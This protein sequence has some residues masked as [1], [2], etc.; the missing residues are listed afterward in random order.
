LRHYNKK[1]AS[2]QANRRR[3]EETLRIMKHVDTP[4]TR[5]QA[6]LARGDITPPVGIYHRM[7]GAAVH[8]QATGVHRPL[9]A[10]LLYLRACPSPSASEGSRGNPRWRSGSDALIIALD[11]CVMDGAEMTGIRAAACRATA[12]EP[13]QVHVTLSHTHGSGWMSRAR[14]HFPGGELIGPYLDE[15]ATKI[16]QLAEQAQRTVLPA[17][18]VYGQGRC[19]LAAQRD[20]W[21]ADNKQYVCGFN[22]T[23]A[24]DDTVLVARI[25]GEDGKCLATIV[26]YACHPTTLA[27]DNTAISPDYV[28]AMREVVEHVTGAPCLFLQGASGDLGP[29]EGFVGDWAVADRNGRQL[30]HAA[31]SALEALPPPG[32]RFVY[33][34][35]VVSGTT[36]GTWRHEPLDAESLRK[37]ERWHVRQQMVELPY[38]HDLP[39]LEETKAAHRKWHAEEENARA[40]GDPA[41][42]RDCRALVEQANRQINRLSVLPSG[43]VFPY[44]V[45]LWKL[46]DALWVLVPGEL[47]QAFQIALR[48]RFPA[49]PVIVATLT[50]DWQPGYLPAASSYGYGI[51]QETIAAVAA[52]SLETLIEAIARAIGTM[53]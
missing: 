1:R 17:T 38:R 26:N 51:Y 21:D 5:C 48:A 12:L 44:R 14:A 7:W 4:Q 49:H 3:A 19:T 20:Y 2:A 16:A 30:G 27:W 6:G 28:G 37:Q 8:D 33:A 43:R 52:G 10:T 13:S 41:K 36:I 11:H 32:T 46:G 22:P 18:I 42:A 15:L 25:S 24:A 23:G 29:R 47:Y 34:G 9:L 40:A 53:L 45:T 35:P 39:D 50:G 31:L